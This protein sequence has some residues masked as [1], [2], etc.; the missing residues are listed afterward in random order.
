MKKIKS[1]LSSQLCTKC[2]PLQFRFKTTAELPELTEPVG[3][4]RALAAIRL[5]LE[6]DQS[7]Y[8]LYLLGPEGTGK[9]TIIDTIVHEQAKNEP[10]PDDWCYVNNFANPLKPKALRL[11]SGLGPILQKD[12]SDLLNQITNGSD[13]SPA[14][15]IKNLKTKY[16]QFPEV[17]DYFNAVHREITADPSTLMEESRYQINVFVTHS[18]QDH[19]PV[20]Y[21]NNPTQANLMGRVDYVAQYGALNTNSSLIRAGSLHRANGGYLIL[22]TSQILNQS[23]AWESLKRSL[24]SGWIEMETISQ[25]GIINT[26]SL[27]PEKIPLQVKVILIGE[28]ILYYL[29]CEHDIQFPDLFK[30]AADFSNHIPRNKQNYSIYTRLIATVAKYEKLLPLDKFAVAKIIDRGSRISGDSQR[31]FTHMRYLSDLLKEG[32]YWAQAAGHT[33]ITESDIQQAIDQQIFRNNRIEQR[34]HEDIKRN[35][36][37]LD[38][39]GAKIGQ[40]NGLSVMQLGTYSFS[41]PAR[42]TATV[43]LGKGEVVDIEREVELGG[44]LHTKGVLI[45]SGFLSGR[46]ALTRHLSIAASLVFEQ[47]YGEVDGDSASVAELAALL[48]AISEIPLKQSFAVTGSINQHGIIQ[49]IGG[50]NEKIEGFFRVCKER[51]LTKEQGVL[52]PVSN[53]QHLMLNDEIIKAT[54]QRKFFIYPIANIDEAMTILTGLPAGKR[55]KKGFFPPDSFN[56]IIEQHLLNYAQL[57]EEEHKSDH[58][59][60]NE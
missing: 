49:G 57:A 13:L 15:F 20:V 50:V 56:G 12:M 27:E 47:N 58:H 37:L 25:T 45:L 23:N 43:H 34:I 59:D 29:L 6:M 42:I 51:G 2:D 10:T 5:G 18:P 1:L 54:K 8:N 38:T 41:I 39:K 35:I 55:N 4:D 3:Q 33:F 19:A 14:T 60:N 26:F 32:D 44:A 53:V 28:R 30:V 40:V 22:D 31:L 7:G 24:A 16:K 36:L 48:S 17:I 21:E 11:P 46:Y 9:H 52:I